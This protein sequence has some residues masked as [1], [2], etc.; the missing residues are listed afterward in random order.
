MSRVV[1]ICS[2][3]HEEA[4]ESIVRQFRGK[5]V[6]SWTIDR[7]SQSTSLH[8]RAIICW[9]DQRAAL[10]SIRD[11]V[12]TVSLGPRSPSASMQAITAARRW[13]DGWRGG[14]LQTCDFDAGFDAAAI[15]NVL[16]ECQA[17]IAALVDPASALVDP[18]IIEALI[19]R[20]RE[21]QDEQMFIAPAAVGL[22]AVLLRRSL[23]EKLA[24]AKIHPGKLLHYLP[25][26]PLRDPIAGD[27]CVD[28]PIAV[29]RSGDSFRFASQRQ[30]ERLTAAMKPPNGQ[31]RSADA[32]TIIE[33]FATTHVIDRFPREIVLE[34]NTDRRAHPIFRPGNIHRQPLTVT[35]A[36]KLF[37]DLSECRDVRLTLAGVGDP[38]E[39]D[40]FFDIVEMAKS[41]GLRAI[42]VETDLLCDEAI[43]TRLGE[44]A[45]DVVTVHL[46]AMTAATYEK[47]MGIDALPLAM[48][49]IAALLKARRARSAGV[50]ILVPTFTKCRQNLGEMEGWYDQWIRAVGC[51]VIVGANDFAGQ[52]VDV[53]VANMTSPRRHACRR[54][55]SRLTILCSGSV[56]TC[57]QDV[58]GRRQIG[59]I[60]N[61]S[62]A[63][64]WMTAMQPM[65]QSHSRGDWSAENPLCGSCLEW[66]RP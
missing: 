49:N 10:A 17:E 35:A 24:A 15:V 47:I 50:P 22:A 34:L 27:G 23:L 41:R 7:L 51:A 1:A 61:Q 32:A 18:R 21:K 64:L 12:R 9:D 31:L 55:R 37:D 62:I 3:L 54:L 42:H 43:A 65:R 14:L 2:L 56:V 53:S 38:V 48:N 60:V 25:D 46:P 6:L 52:I 28:L 16:T 36:Q 5:S 66:N 39:A 58:S 8:E 59:N 44:S 29:K 33:T 19:Q 57:E 40:A 30:T 13:S 4:D 26:Q 63:D 45:I 11:D 20:S